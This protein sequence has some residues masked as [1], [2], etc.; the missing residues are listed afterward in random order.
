MK[1]PAQSGLDEESGASPDDL[2][3]LTQAKA[4]IRADQCDGVPAYS[5]LKQVPGG[6][7]WR[8]AG[9]RRLRP[10]TIGRKCMRRT[11]AVAVWLISLEGQATL[12]IALFLTMCLGSLALLDT[13]PPL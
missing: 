2:G 12:V 11:A 9:H 8:Q 10:G 6:G 1:K 7:V 4:W 3:R 5:A 13:R